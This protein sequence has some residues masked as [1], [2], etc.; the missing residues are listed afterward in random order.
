[1]SLNILIV[2]DEAPARMRLRSLLAELPPPAPQVAEAANAVQ[3]MAALQHG[4]HEVALLDIHLPGVDGLGLA[5]ELRK[6]SQPPALIF[7]T[8]HAEHALR[9]FELE[10]VDYLTKPVRRERLAQALDKAQR[11][12]GMRHADASPSEA[13]LLIQERGRSLRVPLHEVRYVKAELKYLTVRTATQ[14]L[15]LEGSLMDLEARFP[16][17]WLRVHRNALVARQMVRSLERCAEQGEGESW[18]L[19]L[20]GVDEGVQVSRRQMPVVRDA[21]ARP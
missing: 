10:A 14:S 19:R 1:M 12:L 20:D 4:R 15:L 9:A 7:V 3:A 8:A 13:F 17:H 21:L 2:D 5:A 16:A 18:L 6:L 11:W